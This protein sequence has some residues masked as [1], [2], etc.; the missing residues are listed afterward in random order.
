MRASSNH[1]RHW[2]PGVWLEP[3]L[4][5]LEGVCGGAPGRSA[6]VHKRERET[7]ARSQQESWAQ[8]SDGARPSPVTLS[9]ELSRAGLLSK[10]R[11][12]ELARAPLPPSP[13]EAM[14]G[15]QTEEQV[16]RDPHKR[17]TG[18]ARPGEDKRRHSIMEER[19]PQFKQDQRLGGQGPSSSLSNA[20]S[21]APVSLREK[22]S[23]DRGRSL[24]ATASG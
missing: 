10:T 21:P 2:R 19:C 15:V 18:P 14:L 24:K 20:R 8:H 1:G 11:K 13:R 17:A 22:A 5:A 3:G 12:A 16:C 23:A 7:M 9:A 4:G 6:L